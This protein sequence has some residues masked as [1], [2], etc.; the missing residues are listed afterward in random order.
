MALWLPSYDPEEELAVELEADRLTVE[1]FSLGPRM[2]AVYV[3]SSDGGGVISGTIALNRDFPGL[4][5]VH[6]S[7]PWSPLLR[8]V[9]CHELRHRRHSGLHVPRYRFHCFGDERGSADPNQIATDHVEAQ[10]ERET[11]ELLAPAQLI[12][13]YAREVG[14]LGPGELAD[15]ASMLRVPVP[16]LTW[17]VRTFSTLARLPDASWG[18]SG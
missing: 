11:A 7:R 2:R 13:A 9:V 14:P 3:E 1:Y 10:A 15:L 6:G 8:W 5:G 16:P 18:S 12:K 17:Y 4:D